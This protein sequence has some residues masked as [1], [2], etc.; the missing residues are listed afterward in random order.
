MIKIKG[1]TIQERIGRGG[2]AEV[3]KA[4]QDV[5]DR[6]VAIKV[7]SPE[8]EANREFSERFV[9]EAKNAASFNHPNIVTIHDAGK[10][11]NHSYIVMEFAEYGDLS[12]RIARGLKLQQVIAIMKQLCAALSYIHER[13][14]VHRDIKPANIFFRKDDTAVIAD[15]GISKTLSNDEKLTQVGMAIGSP[16][17]MSPEQCMGLELDARSDLYSLGVVFYEMLS[18]RKPY[19]A[20][21]PTGVSMQHISA[22]VPDLPEEFSLFQPVLDRLMAKSAEERYANAAAVSDALEQT[23]HAYLSASESD[24]TRI[25]PMSDTDKTTVSVSQGPTVKMPEVKRRSLLPLMGGGIALLA[26]VALF[27]IFNRPE[28]E[29][30]PPSVAHMPEDE[31]KAP[32]QTPV[33]ALPEAELLPTE[34]EAPSVAGPVITPSPLEETKPQVTETDKEA[35]KPAIKIVRFEGV[36]KSRNKTEARKAAINDLAARLLPEIRKQ[37]VICRKLYP[38]RN[39]CQIDDIIFL[40]TDIPLLGTIENYDNGVYRVELNSVNALPVYQKQLVAQLQKIQ[41]ALPKLENIKDPKDLEKL[42][43]EVRKYNHYAVLA[44]MLGDEQIKTLRKSELDIVAKLVERNAIVSSIEEAAQYILAYLKVRSALLTPPR[45]E[46]YT[47]ITTFANAVFKALKDKLATRKA[48]LEEK[49]QLKGGYQIFRNK[50][51]VL[52]YDLINSY[53]EILNSSVVILKSTAS[54]DFRT[55]AEAP[56]SFVHLLYAPM[57]VSKGFMGEL[58]TNLGSENLLFHKGDNLQL[59]AR[60]NQAGYFYL[61]GHVVTKNSEFSYLLDIN[62]DANNPF[63]MEVKPEQVGQFINLGEYEVSEPFGVEYI[64]M[65]ASNENLRRQLPRYRWDEKLEYY[66]IDESRGNA[67]QGVSIV[68]GLKKLRDKQQR[69]HESVMTITTME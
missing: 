16:D 30:K 3:Y 67:S 18:H 1:Y 6:I 42:F 66:V 32:A 44:L 7:L 31:S 33:P 10:S 23:Y 15:F 26:L 65:I 41:S 53:A 58:T 35:I 28:S 56:Q 59:F 14:I 20:T 8:L 5:F 27:F 4:R 38:Q 55:S 51:I 25:K 45:A 50:Y 43:A 47:E 69:V 64:Q 12:D 57:P 13:G 19:Q 37:D 61:A 60:L 40:K 29:I 24:T 22:P 39:N 17:Y 36:G 49:Y 52:S 9:N 68:R 34:P 46:G 2:M 11:E 48:S 54:L 63:I 62:D 21:D